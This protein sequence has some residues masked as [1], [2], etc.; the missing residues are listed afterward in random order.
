MKKRLFI[1]FLLLL[2]GVV[3]VQA[4]FL[5]GQLKS[6]NS[7]YPPGTVHCNLQNITAVVEVTNPITGRTW[8]DRNLGA[9]RAATSS[10]DALAFGDLYQWG[11]GADGHQ[12][13][14]SGTISTISVLDQPGHDDFILVPTS[15]S[16]DDWRNP[17]N[18]ALWQGV[19]GI[20][21]PCPLGFRVPTAA[22]FTSERQSWDSNNLQGAYKSVLKLTLSGF[23]E[24]DTG[25]VS[26][27]DVDG[28]TYGM[29]WTSSV[30]TNADEAQFLAYWSGNA[31]IN[32]YPR[33]RGY[34]VR[35]I[36][37]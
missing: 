6:S 20:N 8:M 25:V 4:Q 23:R 37:N 27:V 7:F 3:S 31:F 33:S 2:L 26:L 5:G 12:C 32:P 24:R 13:R 17:Q 29:L 36:K 11:R 21:N 35:C 15:S 16:T 9:E 10:T 18:N 28:K 34:A 14:N 30:V 22:E 1:S 19:N